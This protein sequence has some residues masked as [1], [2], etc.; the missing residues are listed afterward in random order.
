MKVEVSVHRLSEGWVDLTVDVV[1]RRGAYSGRYEVYRRDTNRHLG[2]VVKNSGGGWDGYTGHQAYNTDLLAH[3]D[4]YL[5]G[6]AGS[7]STRE[8]ALHELV[9]ELASHRAKGVWE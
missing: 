5:L 3:V 8:D 9:W 2:W 6:Y 4:S 1:L 7:G